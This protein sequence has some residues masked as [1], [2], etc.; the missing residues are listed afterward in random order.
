LSV[1]EEAESAYLHFDRETRAVFLARLTSMFTV[2]MR[3][4]YPEVRAGDQGAIRAM[5]GINEVMHRVAPE[6]V[7]VLTGERRWTEEEFFRIIESMAAAH[8]VT[9]ALEWNLEKLLKEERFAG[10]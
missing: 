8:G 10:G 6:L 2:S 1:I 4:Q 5:F 9:P 3:G 7:D